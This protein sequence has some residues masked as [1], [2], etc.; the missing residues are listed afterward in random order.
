MQRAALLLGTVAILTGCSTDLEINAPY[1]DI[2]VVHGLLN[3][4][5]SIHY[6]KI[7]KAFLGE[8]DALLYAQIQD[9]NEWAPGAI[10]YAQVVRKLNGSVVGTFNLYDTVITDREPGTFYAPEQTIHYF[11]DP[12]TRN[13]P[14]GGT[15][16]TMHLDHDS[17]YEL[18]LRIKGQDITATTNIVNDFS[19]VS[20]DQA[21]TVPIE[22]HNGSQYGAFELNWSSSLDGKRY[23]ADY[24][25][26]Y[27]EVTGTDTVTKRF[28]QRLGTRVSGNPN[29]SE[30]MSV[31]LDGE[32][33]FSSVATAVGNAVVDQRIFMGI[34]L[35]VSVANEEFHTYLTLT[36]PVTGIVQDRPSYSNVAN[37]Y[38]IFGGRYVKYILGKRLGSNSLNQLCDGPVTGTLRFCSGMPGDVVSPHYCP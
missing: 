36:E 7:S 26:H 17:D 27:K 34:D 28:T 8:G 1:K 25:F 11:V 21:T 6:V 10:E 5:D 32:E 16:T 35:T 3:M 18:Q 33:F 20:A 15:P 4:R 24:T 13:I 37:G 19:F 23:V 14:Q 30:P 31:A 29:G 2:T 22:L 9:S 12:F 38:G